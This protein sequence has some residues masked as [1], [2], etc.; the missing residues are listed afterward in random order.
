MNTNNTLLKRILGKDLDDFIRA[1]GKDKIIIETFTKV[2]NERMKG[3]RFVK[4]DAPNWTV[5]RAL[6]D[7]QLKE[8]QWWIKLLTKEEVE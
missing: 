8:I 7:G 4:S 2:L 3:F 6:R 1:V 5:E